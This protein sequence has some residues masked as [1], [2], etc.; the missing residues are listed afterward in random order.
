MT[1]RELPQPEWC[2]CG[3]ERIE[4]DRDGAIKTHW[5]RV[6]PRGPRPARLRPMAD[7]PGARALR[8]KAEDGQDIVEAVG[9]LVAVFLFGL[10]AGVIA[11]LGIPVV[12]IAGVWRLWRKRGEQCGA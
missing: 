6:W 11:P 2:E 8:L 10:F 9:T 4:R 7:Y 5:P 12:V 3:A 1:D